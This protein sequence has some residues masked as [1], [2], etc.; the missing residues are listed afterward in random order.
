[1]CVFKIK[2]KVKKGTKNYFSPKGKLAL[3]F[4]KHYACCSDRRLVEQLNA[5]IDY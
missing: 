2:E 1:V 3:M 4:L 5:N